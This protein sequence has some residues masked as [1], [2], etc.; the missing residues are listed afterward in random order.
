[1]APIYIQE[2]SLSIA[3]TM[4]LA[5]T[6]LATSA[7]LCCGTGEGGMSEHQGAWA[8]N[9]RGPHVAACDARAPA[10]AV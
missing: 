5:N 10:T 4:K 2:H 1:M 9:P 6:V 7:A 3:R 8:E